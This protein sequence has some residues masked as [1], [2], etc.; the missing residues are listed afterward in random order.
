MDFT[1]TWKIT[2]TKTRPIASVK[3]QFEV[4]PHLQSNFTSLKSNLFDTWWS[5]SLKSCIWWDEEQTP[6][7]ASRHMNIWVWWWHASPSLRDVL[8]WMSSQHGPTWLHTLLYNIYRGN[9][10]LVFMS[11]TFSETGLKFLNDLQI[12]FL[13]VSLKEACSLE[14]GFIKWG[15]FEETAH[16]NPTR[17]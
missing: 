13:E 15:L 10:G 5:V 11:V 8:E 16:L 7:T 14:L 6:V 3:L 9:A 4:F 1:S 17:Y 2:S 12:C